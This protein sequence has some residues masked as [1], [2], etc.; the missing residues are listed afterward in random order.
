M[1][2][3][4]DKMYGEAEKFASLFAYFRKLSKLITVYNEI[5]CKISAN[6]L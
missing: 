4:A 1:Y 2:K 3:Y 5:D 6:K